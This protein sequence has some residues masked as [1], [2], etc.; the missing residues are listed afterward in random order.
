M[1][2]GFVLLW[3][4]KKTFTAG[5]FQNGPAA[6]GIPFFFPARN[7]LDAIVGNSG[8]NPKLL[9]LLNSWLSIKLRS[10]D[11]KIDIAP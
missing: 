4:N 8:S 11:H 6:W 9:H 3:R 10:D 7:R 5:D 2:R 1:Q